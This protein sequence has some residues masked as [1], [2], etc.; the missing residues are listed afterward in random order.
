L[1]VLGGGFFAGDIGSD[2]H[3]ILEG[4]QIKNNKINGVYFVGGGGVA[5]TCNGKLVDNV[6]SHNSCTSTAFEANGGGIK[7]FTDPEL[8]SRT[9]LIKRN[10]I[11][12]N[13]AEGKKVSPHHGAKGG[14]I[15][16]HWCKVIILD[17]KILYNRLNAID[18]GDAYGAGIHM[19][20]ANSGSLISSNTISYNSIAE[21]ITSGGG[22]INL[23]WCDISL[24]II[25]NI[26]SGNSALIGG[27]I[28]IYNSNSEIINNTI[29]KNTASSNGGGLYSTD[30]TPVVVN[31]IFWFN[32]AA[33][34]S[35]IY[36]SGDVLY[37]DIQGGWQG[38]GNIDADP[39]FI[40]TLSYDLSDLSPC[41]GS[42]ID[43][44]Q[45][46]EVWYYSPKTDI[47]GH[48]RPNP[49]DLYVDMG[50]KES[51]YLNGID[52]E[53]LEYFP[54]SFSLKQNY[55]NPFNPV[56]AI[57]YQLSAISDVE[58]SIYNLLGQKIATLVSEKQ[59]AGYHQIEWDASG[60]ASGIYYYQLLAGDYMEVKKMILLK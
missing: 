43:S 45:V 37:S 12:H 31:T 5:L 6:I 28:D 55:P 22:G 57:G 18:S 36:G 47:S 54:T 20:D 30:P 49:I 4:N 27:G 34:D 56:T 35:Q 44:I 58:L 39:I 25:N 46:G 11:T 14:G 17:N 53:N 42:G 24:P 16:N 3:V 50:A 19:N 60:F 38:E 32:V 33:S 40:D 8:L 2:A 1:D 21:N 29:V 23:R 10:Y 52:D 7:V 9:V 48:Q 51:D 13:F 15:V 59:K 41:V 26:I